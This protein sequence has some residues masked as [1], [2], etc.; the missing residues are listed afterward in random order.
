VTW[1]IEQGAV[2]GV[3]LL[4]FQLAVRPMPGADTVARSVHLL[5]GGGFDRSLLSFMQVDRFGNVN[6]SR[7]AASRM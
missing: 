4:D 5:Q 1:V 6:V 3:P 7:L 2:G